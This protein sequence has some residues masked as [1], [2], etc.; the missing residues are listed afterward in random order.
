MDG[1]KIFGIRIFG[2]A[3][4]W[5][6]R[7]FGMVDFW[8]GTIQKEFLAWWNF[9]IEDFWHGRLKRIFGMVSSRGFLGI[10]ELYQDEEFLHV[11]P[12]DKGFCM[13]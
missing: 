4:F 2:M 9:G 6:G 8:H 7:I 13:Q 1:G 11:V 5:H 3:E 12:K 10:A